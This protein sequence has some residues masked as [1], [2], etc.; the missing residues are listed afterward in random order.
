MRRK[1]Y[2][3]RLTPERVKANAEYVAELAKLKSATDARNLG[4]A[5]NSELTQA[6]GEDEGWGTLG[7]RRS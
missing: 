4:A 5:L 3:A 6:R 1:E 7:R 2:Q